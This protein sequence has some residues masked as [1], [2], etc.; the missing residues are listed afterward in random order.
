MQRLQRGGGLAVLHAEHSHR[1]GQRT[2]AGTVHSGSSGFQ[3]APWRVAAM[4]RGR[5]NLKH[6]AVS[7]VS[8]Q[9]EAFLRVHHGHA[10]KNPPPL[11]NRSAVLHSSQLYNKFF[12]YFAM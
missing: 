7:D 9:A 8:D 1:S 2:G 3:A 4:G 12:S 10:R 6:A 5:V 11:T